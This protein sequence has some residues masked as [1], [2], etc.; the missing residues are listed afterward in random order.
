MDLDLLVTF[1]EVAKQGNFSRA[2]AKVFR[3]QPA[4]SAHI[5]QLEEEYKQKLFDRSGKKVR[6]TPAGELLLDHAQRMLRI[7]RESLHAV[8]ERSGAVRGVLA[9]GANE[10]TFLYVLPEVFR[11]FHKKYPDVRLDIYRNFSHK[12]LEKIEDGSLDVG[13]VTLPIRSSMMKVVPLFRDD[14]VLAVSASN[15]TEFG[16][17]VTVDEIAKLPLILPRTGYIR[18]VMDRYLRPYRADLRICMELASVVMIKQFV[19]DGFG[20][21]LISPTFAREEAK[22]G[23]IKLI[24][25]ADLNLSRQLGL[26]YRRDRS[27]PRVAQAFIELTKEHARPE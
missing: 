18:R 9:I 2:A 20:V 24:P 23:K 13:I 26:V 16:K 7:H 8:G 12:V 27:Q 19:A 22:A 6:L 5:R 1:V 21:S 10:A 14:L 15:K 17:S 25:V 3:S 4:V 11:R